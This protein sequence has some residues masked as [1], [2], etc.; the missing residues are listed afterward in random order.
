MA[1]LFGWLT[2]PLDDIMHV[3]LLYR[4]SV[5]VLSTEEHPQAASLGI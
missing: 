2:I 3:T 5:T 1:G 4:C